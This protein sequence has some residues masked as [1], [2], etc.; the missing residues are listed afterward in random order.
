M[1]PNKQVS[2]VIRISRGERDASARATHLEAATRK[3]LV[4]TNERKYMSTKTNFKRIALVAVAA[5]GLGVLSS[6]PS[7]AQVT[8]LTVTVTAGAGGVTTSSDSLTAGSVVVSALVDA[9]YDTI[10]VQLVPRSGT[11]QKAYLVL[12]DTTVVNTLLTYSATTASATPTRAGTI[13]LKNSATDSVTSTVG[14]GGFSMSYDTQAATSVSGYV[15]A[16]FRL[17]LDTAPAGITAGTYSYTVIT[18]VI[19]GATAAPTKTVNTNIDFVVSLSTAA[20][21]LAAK[22]VNG[23][24]SSLTVGNTVANLVGTTGTTTDSTIAVAATASA[25]D[26]GFVQVRLRN[27]SGGNAQESLTAT[28]SAGRIGLIG[29]T[30]GRSIDVAYTAAMVSAG[31]VNLAI[32]PDGTSGTGTITIAATSYAFPT[33]SV[34]FYGATTDKV[35]A[36]A[37]ASVIGGSGIGVHGSQFDSLGNSWGAGTDIY[38]YSSDTSVISSYGSACTWNS[39]LKVSLCTLTGVKNGTANITLRDAATVATSTK[40]SSAVAVKVNINA[41][42][43]VALA[44]NKTAYAPGEKATLSITVKDA[45]GAVLPA[46]TYSNLFS[47][48]GLTTS[49]SI[50]SAISSTVLSNVSVVTMATVAASTDTPLVT[51]DPIG[52][53]TFFMPLAGGT[54]TVTGKGGTSLPSSGQVTVTATATVTDSGAAALAAVTALATTVASLKTLITTLTNLVLKIQ[55]KVKA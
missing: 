43:T 17:F 27:A 55:K 38:A 35:T 41:A 10:T 48:G 26:A 32:Q 51:L 11:T 1:T 16:S 40:S 22:A 39:T 47:T 42:S 49:A 19:D 7:Q 37:Y 54:V 34:T 4:T 29:G 13:T 18:K 6:V 23:A 52:Q 44:F 45:A 25:T 46:Q 33:K 5:L 28:I 8:G 53:V 21:G 36:A 50:G 15:G 3:F 31:F 9:A 24:Q 14:A 30:M 2:P 20:A 12:G